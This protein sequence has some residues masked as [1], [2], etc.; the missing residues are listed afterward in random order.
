MEATKKAALVALLLVL[1]IHSSDAQTICKVTVEGLMSCRSAVTPPK[2]TPPSA[3]CCTVIKNSDL[4]C[5]C[6]YKNSS[7]L[8]SLGIDPNLALQLPSKWL[9][10]LL[11][12]GQIRNPRNGIALIRKF[13]GQLDEELRRGKNVNGSILG[14]FIKSYEG[15]TSP[16]LAEAMAI[17][18]GMNLGVALNVGRVLIE[19]DAESI[20]RNCSMSKDP[21]SDI[22]VLKFVLAIEKDKIPDKR[23]LGRSQESNFGSVRD[24]NKWSDVEI[25]EPWRLQKSLRSVHKLKTKFKINSISLLLLDKFFVGNN[26]VPLDIFIF[27]NTMSPINQNYHLSNLKFTPIFCCKERMTISVKVTNKFNIKPSFATLPHRRRYQLSFTDQIA[28]PVFM[29]RV[30]F[31]PRDTNDNL[32]NSKKSSHLKKSL[33]DTLTRF[34]P[35]AGRM[36][37][38]LYV[39]CNDE[40]VPFVEAESKSQLSEVISD[41]IPGEMNHFLP[42]KLDDVRDLLLVV[43]VTFFACGGI[44]VAV[45]ISHKIADA[46]SM[47]MFINGWAATARGDTKIP[48]PQFESATIFP[49][50]DTTGFT[51]STGIDKSD[52]VTK[53]FVF[54]ASKISTLRER[55]SKNNTTTDGE[56]LGHL[57][58]PVKALSALIWT[59]FMV[60]TQARETKADKI[61]SLLHAVNLRRRVN[62]PL[63]ESYFGNIS[64]FAIAVPSMEGEGDG[65][66]VVNT[67]SE[68]IRK[69]GDYVA[70]LQDGNKHLSFVKERAKQ[71]TT[72]EVISFSFTSLCGFP[73]Y[74]PDF[75]WG[76]PQW[77]GSM[78]LTFKNLVVFMDTRTGDGIEA[79]VHLKRE[80]MAKFETD[81][82]FLE[83]VMP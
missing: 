16:R 12:S 81:A 58:S 70:K 75:G 72:G 2:P 27:T 82:E 41:P 10:G 36:V 53:R 30:L 29:P 57:T 6:S 32:D 64:G 37:D 18:N 66:G 5:L 25:L 38:D 49:P 19:L 76:K 35:F 4:K 15:L 48:V 45:G 42:C 40:G 78:S 28:P 74:E 71:T 65:N 83:S 14:I 63:P 11:A 77:V 68:A 79:W 52:I 39:D 17:R 7:L 34:Y 60:A 47:F 51:P 23:D 22:A 9:G 69:I 3:A 31:Y 55:F 56:Q 46:Q 24:E 80:D 44:A 13:Y 20:V 26:N 50:R 62:P 61:Y 8:P 43:Q 21:P 73:L 67:V 33:S 59:R 54:T 1:V